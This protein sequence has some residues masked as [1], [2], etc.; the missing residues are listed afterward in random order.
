M[1]KKLNPEL[2]SLAYG[3]QI[4]LHIAISQEYIIRIWL[5]KFI[6]AKLLFC[7]RFFSCDHSHCWI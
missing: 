6:V 7:N 2:E 1:T 5:K 3:V 4:K